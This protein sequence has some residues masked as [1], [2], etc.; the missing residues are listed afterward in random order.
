M[1]TGEPKSH[2]PTANVVVPSYENLT[3]SWPDVVS[4]AQ[5]QSSP[6]QEFE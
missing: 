4:A 5:T 3:Q 6:W 1:R 2:S